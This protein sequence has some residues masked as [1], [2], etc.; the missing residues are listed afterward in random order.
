[1][2]LFTS[3]SVAKDTS[4]CVG[5]GCESGVGRGEC[6]GGVLTIKVCGGRRSESV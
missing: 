3:L 5:V 4:L 2:V 6:E 1:V